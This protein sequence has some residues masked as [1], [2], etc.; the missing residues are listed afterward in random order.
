MCSKCVS[1]VDR[2]NVVGI[3]IPVV[4]G[5][6][7]WCDCFRTQL[8]RSDGWIGKGFQTSTEGQ[9][10]AKTLAFPEVC[11]IS[12]PRGIWSRHCYA[13]RQD[14]CYS[15]LAFVPKHHRSPSVHGI[16]QIWQIFPLSLRRCINWWRRMWSSYNPDDVKTRLMSWKKANVRAYTRVTEERRMLRFGYKRFRLWPGCRTV[17]KAD[18]STFRSTRFE[19]RPKASCIAI[20]KDLS[21]TLQGRYRKPKAGTT[22]HE[23]NCWPWFSALSN[24]VSTCWD[25]TLWFEQITLRF[26][27]YD[28]HLNLCRSWPDD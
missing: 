7:E 28:E 25:V 27:G 11:G 20:R 23:R 5:S 15:G 19:A 18:R 17:S 22:R 26:R 8:W 10:E 2:L 13:R 21:S 9:A 16:Q 3:V 6:P 1:T 24:I 12:W 4:P 14:R